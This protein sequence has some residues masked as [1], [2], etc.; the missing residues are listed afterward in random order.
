MPRNGRNRRG[1][2]V[3]PPVLS[4]VAA[5]EVRSGGVS[6]VGLGRMSFA[7]PDF[8][9][10][11]ADRGWLDPEKVCV[12]C[13]ACTQIMRD[14]GR[15]G[16]VPRD[17]AIYEPIYKAGREEAL[18]TIL[19]MA[20]TCRQCNDPTCVTRCPAQV[21]IPRFVG[22]IA[23]GRFREAYETLREANVLAAVCG[24]V[25]PSETL[26]E[27]GCINQHYTATVPIRHMQRWV[28][29]KAV[30]EG[31]AAE[32]RPAARKS[33]KRVQ[34]WE[35]VRQASPRRSPWLRSGTR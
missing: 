19:E 24:F 22:H 16:C 17:A 29:R 2:L 25:C 33:G 14:G 20:K 30:E 18:D 26:C 1:I 10:D 27:A 32:S 15:S 8:A 6:L 13:S 21:N 34:C 12:A 5:A 11:L 3:A 35:P 28:G 31:W 7:Y 4:Y 23:E 9:R